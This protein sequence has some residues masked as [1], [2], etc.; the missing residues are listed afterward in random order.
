MQLVQNMYLKKHD[1]TSS[2]YFVNEG[3]DDDEIGLLSHSPYSFPSC[4]EARLF[5]CESH[6]KLTQGLITYVDDTYDVPAKTVVDNSN[7]WE[8]LFF[9]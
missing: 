9:F 5:V 4:L 2:K 3:S 8:G 6:S 7:V 1:G